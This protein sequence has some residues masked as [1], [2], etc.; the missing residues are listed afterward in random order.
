MLGVTRFVP[1]HEIDDSFEITSM[2]AWDTTTQSLCA[3]SCGRCATEDTANLHTAP[4]LVIPGLEALLLAVDAK[5]SAAI[6]TTDT[7]AARRKV[8]RAA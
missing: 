7:A 8:C 4:P 1:F 5:R 2:C 3:L 6:N